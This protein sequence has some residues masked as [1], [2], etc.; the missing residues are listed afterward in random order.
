MTEKVPTPLGGSPP[1]GCGP[2][3]SPAGSLASGRTAA[4]AP[5]ARFPALP[6]ARR[7]SAPAALDVTGAQ[8]PP[9]VGR[10][11]CARL[12]L[13]RPPALCWPLGAQAPGVPP[14]APL[15]VGAAVWNADPAGLTPAG[16]GSCALSRGAAFSSP[17]NEPRP[18]PGSTCCELR[19]RP[20]RRERRLRFSLGL[21]FFVVKHT[22]RDG[23]AA[24]RPASGAFILHLR[25]RPHCT[26]SALVSANPTA[27]A[28]WPRPLCAPR[29]EPH[30]ARRPSVSA[31][32]WGPAHLLAWG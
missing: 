19:E 17:R 6:S 10:P 28:L 13:P 14:P 26:R 1:A 23:H 24:G 11:C 20:P 21:V 31:Q 9:G 8:A 7:A 5:R 29:P 32:S 30:G 22:Q 4:A 27:V 12:P 25:D 15:H 2:Q 16:L 3:A 18:H